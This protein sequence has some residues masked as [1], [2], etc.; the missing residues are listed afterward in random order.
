[1][2]RIL[3]PTQSGELVVNKSKFTGY[4]LV[5]ESRE[6]FL[7]SINTITKQTAGA[8][9]IAFAYQIKTNQGTDAYFNDAGEP[10]GTAGK[11]LLNILEKRNIVNS[12]LA[13]VRFYGGVNLG[14]GGLVRAY[15]R[16]GMLAIDKAQI[17]PFIDFVKYKLLFKYNILDQIYNVINS[18][19]G[20][21]IDKH[22]DQNITL[23]A[24]LTE[25]TF[26]EIKNYFPTIN[27]KRLD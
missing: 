16:S 7:S 5:G 6:D 4:A 9:H 27:I 12:G 25:K 1:L 20:I 14:T 2:K 26:Q 18:N 8:N 11:P 10:S 22:F 23:T 24:K 15:T 3:K 19:D 13:V 21:I 17:E